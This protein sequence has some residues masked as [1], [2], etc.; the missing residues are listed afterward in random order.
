MRERTLVH[1]PGDLAR[2]IDK[3]VGARNRSSF[4]A[5]VV[6]REL[7]RRE[8]QVAVRA[9]VGTWKDEDHA[10]LAEG[11]ASYIDKMRT[12]EAEAE[13]QRLNQL[14]SSKNA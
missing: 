10:E 8:Q 9:A 4:T 11:S 6:R 5:E 14:T 1:L 12:A 7:K 13:R 2:G 3:L